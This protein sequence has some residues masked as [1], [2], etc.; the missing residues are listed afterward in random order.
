MYEVPS[1]ENAVR[2]II[3]EEAAKGEAKPDL[4]RDASV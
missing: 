1:D 4:I 2:C 3:T